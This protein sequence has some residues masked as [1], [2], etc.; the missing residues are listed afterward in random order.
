MFVAKVGATQ[1][2]RAAAA[3]LGRPQPDARAYHLADLA[4]DEQAEEQEQDEEQREMEEYERAP[5]QQS[6]WE[7]KKPEALPVRGADGK[8]RNVLD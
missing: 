7:Q 6:K 4:V 8:W 5:R 2:C 3:H 1:P